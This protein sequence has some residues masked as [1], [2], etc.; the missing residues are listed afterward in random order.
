[1]MNNYNWIHNE[2]LLE[3]VWVDIDHCV[4]VEVR[5]NNLDLLQRSLKEPDNTHWT[6]ID[7]VAQEA[8]NELLGE[9]GHLGLVAWSGT[10]KLGRAVWLVGNFY[11]A[12]HLLQFFLADIMGDFVS[13]NTRKN[14]YPF[15][16]V[17]LS[18]NEKWVFVF[19]H[20]LFVFFV[21][22]FSRLLSSSSNC[23]KRKRYFC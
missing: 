14:H 6:S 19:I 2:L 23:G 22:Y 21:F 18:Y 10:W 15:G 17:A 11:L 5:L 1:M 7:R 8:S 13:L 20:F 16:A 9:R 3:R 12:R 4:A